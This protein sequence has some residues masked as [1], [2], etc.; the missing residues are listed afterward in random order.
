M[1]NRAAILT[2]TIAASVALAACGRA[3]DQQVGAFEKGQPAQDLR[4]GVWAKFGRSTSAGR[5]AG[6]ADL[7]RCH[8]VS[9]WLG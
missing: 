2:A 8:G 6:Q 1:A 9:L 4:E 5:Q 7:L 3:T